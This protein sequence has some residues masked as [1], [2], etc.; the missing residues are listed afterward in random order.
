MENTDKISLKTTWQYIKSDLARYRITEQRSTFASF[1][2][3]P[4][5][6]AGIYYRLGHWIWY[7]D[8]NYAQALMLL[9]PFYIL[10]KRLVEIYTGISVSPQAFIGPGLYFNH[11]GSIFIGASVIGEN[12]NFAHE[13]TVGIA[14]RGS[15]RG[16]P[17]LGD[18]IF[19]GPGAKILGKINIG[20][21]VA[22]GANA[23]VTSDLPDCAVAVGI[24][25]KIISYN[26]S[27]DFIVYESK[28]DNDNA[29]Q[30]EPSP[31]LQMR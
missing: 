7:A 24:P 20:N 22:V 2:F 1:I 3:S 8:S 19:V 27:F 10:G 9:R 23:V 29:K 18:R 31:R 14:G 12:C 4:G 11:F 15:K 17:V 5:V 13:V 16:R 26:G 30:P 28:N 6:L 25:A 21:D